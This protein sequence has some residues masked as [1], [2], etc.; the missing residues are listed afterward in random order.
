VEDREGYARLKRELATKEWPN[1]DA[2]ANAKTAL[3][4]DIIAAAQTAGEISK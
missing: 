1:M 2:Y 3:I 4:E